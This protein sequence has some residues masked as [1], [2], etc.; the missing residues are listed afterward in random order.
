MYTDIDDSHVGGVTKVSL[1]AKNAF[2]GRIG[3]RLGTSMDTSWGKFVPYARVNIWHSF[4]GSDS[5]VFSDT[6][7]NEFKSGAGY[8]SPEVALGFTFDMTPSLR[9]YGE[10]GHQFK[11]GSSDTSIH[12]M[13][14]VSVGMKFTF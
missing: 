11:A 6:L 2:T 3:A 1:D 4:S 8:T 14:A 13:N 5:L 7:R 10:L 9:L 12:S